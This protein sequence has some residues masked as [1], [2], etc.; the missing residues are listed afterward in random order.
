MQAFETSSKLDTQKMP[1]YLKLFYRI[2]YVRVA[3]FD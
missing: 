2:F 3:F 1:K